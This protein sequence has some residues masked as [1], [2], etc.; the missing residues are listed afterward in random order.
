MPAIGLVVAINPVRTRRHQSENTEFAQLIL[1]CV[2]REM[3]PQ[4][5]LS[6][7]IFPGVRAKQ[8][9]KHLRA[10]FR[11]QH[12]QGKPMALHRGTILVSTA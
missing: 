3:A 12:F 2:K 5:E 10:H 8:Q 9:L 6:H 4:C 11:E 1:D 7:I